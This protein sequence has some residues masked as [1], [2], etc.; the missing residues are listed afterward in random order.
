[1]VGCEFVSISPDRPNIFYEVHVRTDIETDMQPLLD[2]LKNHK[3][4]TPR[5][6]VFCRSL[7]T[8][9]DLYAHFHYELGSGSYFP[10]GSEQVIF[11]PWVSRCMGFVPEGSCMPSRGRSPREDIQLHEGTNPI[12]LRNPW[13]R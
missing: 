13:Y 9:A 7:N 2:S 3:A 4:N 11:V 6:N 1:M 5:V 8:C 12:H 10:A